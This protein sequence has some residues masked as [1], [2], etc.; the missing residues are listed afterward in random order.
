MAFSS[1]RVNR[2]CVVVVAV[3]AVVIVVVGAALVVVVVRIDVVAA[4]G[5]TVVV[6]WASPVVGS[7]AGVGSELAACEQ[8]ARTRTTAIARKDFI[9][10]RIGRRGMGL[11]SPEG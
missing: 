9:G 10:V 11:Q 5:A 3:G 7:G 8:A 2:G 1:D 4:S 6:S